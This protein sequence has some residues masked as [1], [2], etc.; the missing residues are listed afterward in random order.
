MMSRLLLVFV[1]VACPEP[2]ESGTDTDRDTDTEDGIELENGATVEA[3]IGPAGGSL[4]SDDGDLTLEIPPGALSSD[5]TVSITQVGDP[6]SGLYSLEPDGLRFDVPATAR[7]DAGPMEDAGVGPDEMVSRMAL[8]LAWSEDGTVEALEP[9][10]P[11]SC[12]LEEV[13]FDLEHFS[14]HVYYVQDP[15]PDARLDELALISYA[16]WLPNPVHVPKVVSVGEPARARD[17]HSLT[18]TLVFDTEALGGSSLRYDA[19]LELRTARLF[20]R[21]ADE[22]AGWRDDYREIVSLDRRF[23][24][25]LEVTPD[26]PA[27]PLSGVVA[28]ENPGR[29][30]E[31][32]LSWHAFVLASA[33]LSNRFVASGTDD[34][35]RPRWR[36]IDGTV[37]LSEVT[38]K[39]SDRSRLPITCEGQQDVPARVVGSGGTVDA[40]LTPVKTDPS[41][42]ET[43]HSRKDGEKRKPD[44]PERIVSTLDPVLD[45]DDAA[46]DRL[47]DETFP[48][49]PTV[50]G[51]LTVCASEDAP[52][53]GEWVYLQTWT[54]ADIPQADPDH[55]RQLAFVFDADGVESNNYVPPT[56]FE[57]D[58]FAGTDRWYQLRYEPDEGWSVDVRDWRLDEAASSRPSHARFVILG[59][60]FA[61]FVPREELDGDTPTFRT[62]T[63]RH[64]GDYGL[65]GRPW[66]GDLYPNLEEELLPAAIGTVILEE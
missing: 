7:I 52:P 29:E 15:G 43:Q 48:C 18:S 40:I 65:S 47:F 64:D 32:P 50:D 16:L 39:V 24:P 37:R 46:R 58:F 60:A 33:E 56:D 38:V 5:E 53:A 8:G 25:A 10:G 21:E 1:L 26:R 59:H 20:A 22:H 63:F 44:P 14:L 35:G 12:G 57:N 6:G 66:S 49:G 3:V 17:A 13:C 55:I 11:E 42:D 9:S 34:R 4:T 27:R 54:E 19:R 2:P 62:T 61:L 23:E 30:R 51:A 31:I 36:A 28:C 45:L 41:D